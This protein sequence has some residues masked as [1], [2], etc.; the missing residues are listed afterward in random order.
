MLQDRLHDAV[1]V[2]VDAFRSAPLVDDEQI[3][4]ILLLKGI[5]TSIAVRI[6]EFVPLAYVRV[7][8]SNAGVQFTD[9]SFQR[10]DRTGQIATRDLTSEPVWEVARTFAEEERKRGVSPHD[11]VLVAGRSAEFRAA[12]DLRKRGS[13]LENLRF[14][15]PLLPWPEEG[16]F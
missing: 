12:N 14:T 16:P 9:A 6:V 2:A 5:E 10:R 15:S 8:L 7:L 11:F 4:R 3:L 13:K 1:S